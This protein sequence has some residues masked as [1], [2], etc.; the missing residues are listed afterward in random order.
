MDFL[1]DLVGDIVADKASKGLR[2]V[3]SRRGPSDESAGCA[4]KII[5]GSQ[6]GLSR[7][8]RLGAAQVAPGELRFAQHGIVRPPV[9]VLSAYQTAGR[10]SIS[11]LGDCFVAQLQTP[12]ATLALA[13]PDGQLA[14]AVQDLTR[15]G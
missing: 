8:W 5:R 13:M 10:L 11:Q 4:L 3:L 7:H 9:T 15:S 12:T 1:S 2:R 14:L 6:D